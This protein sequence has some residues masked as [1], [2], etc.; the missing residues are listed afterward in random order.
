MGCF[1]ATKYFNVPRTSLFCLCKN[2][3]L[4]QEEAAITMLARKPA[5][6]VHIESL[7]V[8]Y[9]LKVEGKFQGLTRNDNRMSGLLAKSKH[10]ENTF[11]EAHW[12]KKWLKLYF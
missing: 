7:L 5:L 10:L 11:G 9:I 8:D 3:D 2:S 12:K 1:K 6:G 4:S